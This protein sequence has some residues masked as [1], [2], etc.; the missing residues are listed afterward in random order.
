MGTIC[1][2]Q[3]E[4]LART[5]GPR[6]RYDGVAHARL[7]NVATVRCCVTIGEERGMISFWNFEITDL[8]FSL[9]PF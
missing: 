8:K 5:L 7:H 6:L 4:H 9:I 3:S 2:F 1:A